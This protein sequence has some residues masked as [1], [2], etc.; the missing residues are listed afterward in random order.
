MLTT[1]SVLTLE[2]R[3]DR[4][5]YYVYYRILIV[6][7]ILT[8]LLSA[9]PRYAFPP[10]NTLFY[11][12]LL[13]V[14]YI[15]FNILY[16]L[17]LGYRPTQ[18]IGLSKLMFYID[19]IVLSLCSL[20][21]EDVDLTLGLISISVI[22]TSC[23]LFDRI[24]AFI[25]T[26][27]ITFA[28]CLPSL[29]LFAL[30]QAKL[31]L[32]TSGALTVLFMFSSYAF[33][34]YIRQ[35]FQVLDIQNQQQQNLMENL[36]QHTAI[37]AHEIRNPL[38]VIVQ[39]NQLAKSSDP[40]QR[41]ILD[42]MIERQSQRINLII[43]DTIEVIKSEKRATT[44]IELNKFLTTLLQQDLSDIQYAVRYEIEPNLYI[45]FDAIQLGQVLINLIRNA[46]R[47]NSP[48]VDFIQ[49][50]LYST[51]TSVIID[52]IDFGVGVKKQDVA[53]LFKAFYSTETTGTGLGLYLSQKLCQQNQAQLRYVVQ[54]QQGA[55]FRIECPRII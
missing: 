48:D 13:I 40:Q 15:G 23:V 21:L 50:K 46:I 49:L 25:I 26:L 2:T 51:A 43:S 8:L 33:C 22:I 41:Q 47:H 45:R 19:V 20:N 9:Q 10:I 29:Y 38:A 7:S 12:E 36:T 5:R 31:H 17:S 54:K 11:P 28:T 44:H 30:H 35:R 27:I 52:V 34:Q 53:Q 24:Q 3:D 16:L 18:H 6:I 1:V 39:A 14:F 4:G 37:L 42:E 55:C 32:A